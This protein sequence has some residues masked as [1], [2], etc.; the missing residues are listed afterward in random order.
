MTEKWY[1]KPIDAVEAMF[2]TNAASGLSPKAARARRR[3]E[4]DNAVFALPHTSALTYAA[5]VCSDVSMLLLVLTAIL[6]AVWGHGSASSLILGVLAL[7]CAAA[8]FTYIKSRR[9]F[10]SMAVCTMPRVRVLRGGRVFAIDARLL[11]RGDV[12][13]LSPGD[14]I[15]CDARL[16][17]TDGL[18]VLEY[19]GKLNGKPQRGRAV[20]DA[21]RVL[22]DAGATPVSQQTNMV[23]A[24]SVVL[25]GQGSAIVV[26]TGEHTFL[27]STEGQIPLTTARDRLPA[28]V[29][30]KRHCGRSSL[31]MLVLILPLTALGLLIP[32]G[33]LNLLD[34]FLLA[35]SLA[36]SSMSELT[37]AI[38]YVIVG[39]GVLR[40]AAAKPTGKIQR[41]CPIWLIC[42]CWRGWTR[43]PC[44]TI[45]RS[46]R[47]KSLSQ[48]P[49]A[50]PSLSP[51]AG[52]RETAD[53]A[54]CLKRR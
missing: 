22:S 50:A 8:I 13:L 24:G 9:I 30:L 35:L 11:V 44:L 21:G 5:Y 42:P 1:A 38:G 14:V 31:F 7:H 45:P 46:P 6:A 40:A 47:E 10:E 18:E 27:V 12:I 25:A 28:L 48:P 17:A 53:C 52:E 41:S 29:A 43:S 15:S 2:G 36:V 51:S 49:S 19:S 32:G 4:G 16:C 3:E 33:E 37:A 26:E 39:C 20:K 23:F 54:S 34:Y